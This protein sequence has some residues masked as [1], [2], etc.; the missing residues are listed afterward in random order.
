MP[1]INGWTVVL[2]KKDFPKTDGE[3]LVQHPM[4][5]VS[6]Q[7]FRDGTFRRAFMLVAWMELPKP[8]DGLL[9]QGIFSY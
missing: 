9:P 1:K 5:F 8:L 4:G 6:I 2:T 7:E 3:Y